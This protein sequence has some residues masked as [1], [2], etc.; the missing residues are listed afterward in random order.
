MGINN[1]T[2]M[3]LIMLIN[4]VYTWLPKM[5]V[6]LHK[7]VMNLSF[8]PQKDMTVNIVPK[9][10]KIPRGTSINYVTLEGREGFWPRIIRPFSLISIK[11]SKI[12]HFGIT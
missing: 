9:E 6:I 5:I 10:M 1:P 4:T 7:V 2:Y 11:L 3:Q 12:A 8:L